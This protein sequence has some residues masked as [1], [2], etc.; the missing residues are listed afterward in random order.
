MD[1]GE[2]Q[3]ARRNGRF[4]LGASTIY[5]ASAEALY[6]RWPSPMCIIVDGP[7]GVGGFPGDH[8]T[9]RTLADWYRPHIETWTRCS[10]PQ[11]TLWFWGTEVGWASVHPVFAQ[12]DWEYRACNVWDKG[13][14]HVAGNSNTQTLRKFP[15]VTEVCVQYTKA[16]RFAVDGEKVSMQQWLRHEWRRTGLPFRLANDACE[17]QNAATRKYL[18]PDHLW[19][20]PPPEAFEKLARYANQHGKREGC[21]YFSIDH[22]KPIS[23]VEWSMLRSKFRCEFG[24]TN[25]WRES[26]VGGSERIQGERN[27][28]RY[29]FASLHG[30]QKPRKF[31]DL[32]VRVCTDEGDV[33]W[34]PFGGL[35]PGA[36]ASYDLKRK[37]YGAEIVPEFYYA[38]TERLARHAQAGRLLPA[39]SASGSR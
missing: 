7:Y 39:I 28:M 37:Y 27:G 9:H 25:V 11:T 38:A 23:A 32:I 26:Q 19:Y 30:S 20:Y 10:T 36:I 16:A 2:A 15:V 34:E 1:W 33:V 29:K 14:S 31:I 22:E 5:F 24:I 13:M 6:D 12:N 8:P 21:P 4:R 3:L 18:S 17:V 35:C